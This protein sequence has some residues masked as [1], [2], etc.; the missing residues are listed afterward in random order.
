MEEY[1]S[2]TLADWQKVCKPVEELI[3]NASST[4]GEDSWTQWPIGMGYH[5]VYNFKK[6]IRSF[7][8]NHKIAG[9]LQI[10]EHDH[11]VL[12][13]FWDSSD[14]KR[15]RHGQVNRQV[16]MNDLSKNSIPNLAFSPECYFDRLPKYKFVVSPEGNGIDCHRHYESLIAGCI[17][18]IEDN[19][20]TKKKYENMPVLYSND[21]SEITE[22]YLLETY[23]EMLYKKYDFSKLFLSN[24]DLHTRDEIKKYGSFW[25]NRLTRR[26]WYY[27]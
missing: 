19:S 21:Y 27:I 12:C 15:R 20:L 26:N 6:G 13:A 9:A 3:V 8:P 7:L 24:Y 5:Y 23:D 22:E 17:P 4:D 1:K 25:V 10:G 14:T 2:I 16:I 18:I 11:T